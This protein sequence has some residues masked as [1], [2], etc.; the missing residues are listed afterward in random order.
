MEAQ[1]A[2]AAQAASEAQAAPRIAAGA[3]CLAIIIFS[4]NDCVGTW[5][6]NA[7]SGMEEYKVTKRKSTFWKSSCPYPDEQTRKPQNCVGAWQPHG[8]CSVPRVHARNNSRDTLPAPG[9]RHARN[10][11]V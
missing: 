7:E 9:W 4:Q 11:A 5:E 6:F 2:P 8:K 3:A 10:H 1:A